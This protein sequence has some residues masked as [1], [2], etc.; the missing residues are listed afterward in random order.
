MRHLL[1]ILFTVVTIQA[2][3]QSFVTYK[4]TINRFSINIPTGWNYGVNKNYPAI[5]LLAYRTALS[6]SD[7]SRDNFNINIIET[8]GKNLDKTFSD[9]LRY[10]PDAKNFKLINKGDT[11]FNG[12]KFKWLIETHKNENNDKQMHNYDFVTLKDGKTY[13]LTMITSSYDFDTI[14][15]LFAKIASS[16]TLLD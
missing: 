3:G 11:T 16:F 6:K 10:L 2:S 4:D 14:K 15:F 8:P 12:L 7:S 1:L 9:F 5:K 13:I